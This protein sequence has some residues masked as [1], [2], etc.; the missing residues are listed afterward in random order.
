MKNGDVYEGH[1]EN[2][3]RSVKGLLKMKNK[4]IYKGM[5]A[6]DLFNGY[7]LITWPNGE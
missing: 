7:G 2:D 3:K 1:F 4:S 6:N 5:F